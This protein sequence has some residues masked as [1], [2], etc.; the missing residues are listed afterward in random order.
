VHGFSPGPL[1]GQARFQPPRRSD[2][3]H[4]PVRHRY[5]R[6]IFHRTV[7]QQAPSIAARQSFPARHPALTYFLL[8]FAISWIGA[9]SLVATKLLHNQPIPKF[10]GL[11][12]FPIMLLGPSLS[13]ILLTGFIHGRAGLRDLFSR[14]RRFRVGPRWYLPL[15]I[16]PLAI[17]I[18]LFSLKFFVSTIF[19]PNFFLIGILFG[20][21]AGLLEE[22]GW[23]GLAF[24]H[25]NR[26]YRALP[27]AILLGILWGAWHLPVI[28]YLGGATPHASYW[29]PYFLS[30]LVAMTAIRVIISWTYVHTKSVLLAQLLHI[31]S[32]GSLVIF[33]PSNVSPAQ[34]TGW[35]CLYA[36]VLWLIVAI[37][38]L[39]YGKRLTRLP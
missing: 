3:A 18:V 35:Y 24:P 1:S 5:F 32:T 27:A 23:T 30:F 7:P 19:T 34:E 12:M 4:H 6:A 39:A 36:A 25:L 37:L 14:M 38:T 28:D 31:S 9:F 26:Q 10:T 8:T 21:P 16:P 29:L 20:I 13:G 11:L 17:C 15:L 22:I 2:L 33:S